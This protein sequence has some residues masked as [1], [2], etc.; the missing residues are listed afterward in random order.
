LPNRLFAPI[1]RGP[2]FGPS[3]EVSAV[4]FTATI[5]TTRL[6]TAAA[7]LGAPTDVA[8][9]PTPVHWY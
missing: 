4:K 9:V 6:T 2:Q 7:A 1:I 3:F 5:P 8:G